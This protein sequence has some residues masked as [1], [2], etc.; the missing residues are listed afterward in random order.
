MK[1]DPKTLQ[2]ANKSIVPV[3][4]GVIVAWNATG[5]IRW[6][7]GLATFLASLLVQAGT[8]VLNDYSDH[9]AGNDAVNR[10]FVRPFTGGSRMI[11]LGLMTPVE[12]LLLG[13]GLCA[14]AAAVGAGIALAERP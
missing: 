4:L 8:N 2:L 5:Q 7:L 10:E 11:Q 9:R 13:T 6:W 14:P 1:G 3:A 12:T